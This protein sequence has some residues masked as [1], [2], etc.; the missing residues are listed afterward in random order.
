MKEGAASFLTKPVQ[1]EQLLTV[2][3]E[4]IDSAGRRQRP[5]TPVLDRA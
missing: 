4:L 1:E 3:E 5:S 2:V